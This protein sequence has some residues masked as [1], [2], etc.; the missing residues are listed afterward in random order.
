MYLQHTQSL[1]NNL[2]RLL[3]ANPD[4]YAPIVGFLDRVTQ[5]LTQLTWA[6][7]EQIGAE[8]ALDSGS[9]FCSGVRRATMEALGDAPRAEP[10]RLAPILAFARRV[11]RDANAI[12]PTDIQALRAHGWTDQTVEDV[13]GLV[14]ILRVYS[15]LATALG[16]GAVPD[17]EFKGIGV[18][19][20]GA[21]GYEASFDMFVAAAQESSAQDG[22]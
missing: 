19:T 9:P 12:S 8:L 1:D 11:N 14:A 21:G 15:T 22:G 20:V 2:L 16:F 10:G 3:M 18:G 6:D 13:V 5:N 17:A 7:C 4:R